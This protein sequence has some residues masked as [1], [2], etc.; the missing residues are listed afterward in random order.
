MELGALLR[1]PGV[2]DV[3]ETDKALF[4]LTDAPK[5]LP[6]IYSDREVVALRPEEA[7]ASERLPELLSGISHKK[8]RLA[9][10]SG[11]RGWELY[12]FDLSGLPAS[13]KQ[14]FAHAL[15]GTGGRASE[16]GRLGG[17]RLGRSAVLVPRGNART[18]E[19]WL[20]HKGARW[21]RKSVLVEEK[22]AA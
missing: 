19:E 10:R 2:R 17:Q 22:D 3:I 4:I 16:L 6:P 7:L 14:S 15:Y 11:M 20:S 8:G 13:G 18:F 21:T 9:E 5:T 12:E 1:H